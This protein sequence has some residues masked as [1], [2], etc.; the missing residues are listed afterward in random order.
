MELSVISF[1]FSVKTS[2]AE[3]NCKYAGRVLW[4]LKGRASRLLDSVD[5]AVKHAFDLGNSWIQDLRLFFGEQL[6]V[7]CEQNVVFQFAGRAKRDEQKLTKFGVGSPSAAF[8]NICSKRSCCLPYLASQSKHFLTWENTCDRV[9][10]QIQGVSLPPHVQFGVIL[11]ASP[12][13][14]LL[15]IVYLQYNINNCELVPYAN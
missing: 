10:A 7:P 2:G 13:L 15:R 3:D 14:P 9:Q 8:S 4:E 12:V 1:K 11:H 5:Q 6:Q